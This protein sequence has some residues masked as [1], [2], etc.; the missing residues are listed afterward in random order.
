M[1]LTNQ[2]ILTKVAEP[3][4]ACLCRGWVLG[5][6]SGIWMSFGNE[7]EWILAKHV[8][9]VRLVPFWRG[10][11]ASRVSGLVDSIFDGTRATPPRSGPVYVE[12]VEARSPTL[13]WRRGT[14]REDEK[15]R[16][17]EDD[18]KEEQSLPKSVVTEG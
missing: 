10:R 18:P 3:H 11:D 8:R 4:H 13:K 14:A 16:G 5:R 6:R 15:K 9:G 7:D 2:S 1:D 17:G 12:C